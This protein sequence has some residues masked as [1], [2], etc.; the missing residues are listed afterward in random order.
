WLSSRVFT[1]Y[2]DTVD[3]CC[4]AWNRLI[5][6]PWSIMSIGLRDWANA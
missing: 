6:Q 1:S 3:H 4:Y 2:T 5:D